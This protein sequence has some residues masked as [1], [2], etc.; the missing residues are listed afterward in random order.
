MQF[1]KKWKYTLILV[2][3]CFLIFLAFKVEAGERTWGV[4]QNL[5]FSIPISAF[6]FIIYF[7]FIIGI[8]FRSII[9]RFKNRTK[10]SSF[11]F[12]KGL[13]I[14]LVFVS[15]S[16][17]CFSFYVKNE[18]HLYLEK[19]INDLSY[20][21]IKK[22]LKNKWRLKLSECDSINVIDPNLDNHQRIRTLYDAADLRMQRHFYNGEAIEFMLNNFT[23][24]KP[25]FALLDGD[26]NRINF[27][28]IKY[29]EHLDTLADRNIQADINFFCAGKFYEYRIQIP[30]EKIGEYRLEIEIGK[31]N[32]YQ[33]F[34]IVEPLKVKWNI[35][36]AF[37][38]KIDSIK[39]TIRNE[40]GQ[41]YH[42]GYGNNFPFISS[43]FKS[44]R[45]GKIFNS[46]ILYYE[47]CYTGTYYTPLDKNSKIEFFRSN[48][49]TNLFFWNY[50]DLENQTDGQLFQSFKRI[51]G[52]SV[53]IQFSTNAY[54]T[55]WADFDSQIVR[56]DPL[57]FTT[58]DLIKIY[59]FFISR[60]E[61]IYLFS[62]EIP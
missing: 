51:F 26:S 11:E 49:L 6:T 2:L 7:L 10:E 46:G 19:A 47:S 14:L 50:K 41:F 38:L 3:G 48:D 35:E 55:W 40:S 21:Y 43:D 31:H 16:F 20:K 24:H 56:S 60:K 32:L 13:A 42:I 34:K 52:D 29:Y 28:L 33:E 23:M 4:D 44:Y 39:F 30:E 58:E 5:A 61:D 18:G 53:V 37:H 36:N 27:S 62:N 9:I 25:V 1:I 57:S 45:N 15:F 59:K 22:D 8:V 17:F 54:T 12:L